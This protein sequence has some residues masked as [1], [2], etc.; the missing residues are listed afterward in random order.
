MTGK[1][2]RLAALGLLVGSCAGVGPG[3]TGNDTGGI[4]PYT[5]ENRA[6]ASETA[7]IH[8]ARYGKRAHLTGVDARYGGYISFACRFDPRF[9][10]Y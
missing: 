3:L 10:S 1:L 4:I 2:L 9:R 5:P 8:C 7:A 6:H